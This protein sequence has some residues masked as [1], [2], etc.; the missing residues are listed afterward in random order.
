MP[1]QQTVKAFADYGG[2]AAGALG[3]RVKHF[4]TINL[5]TCPGVARSTSQ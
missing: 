5:P 2:Y 1:R 4:V 3:D